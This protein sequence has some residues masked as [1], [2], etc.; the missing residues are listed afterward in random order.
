MNFYKLGAEEALQALGLTLQ[1]LDADT[2]A[3]FAEEDQTDQHTE[4]PDGPPPFAKNVDKAPAWSG[5]NSM[6]AGDAGTRN[7]QLGLPR[8]GAV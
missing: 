8:S 2:F 7:Y 4:S 3:Q 6:E 1:G 5:Q